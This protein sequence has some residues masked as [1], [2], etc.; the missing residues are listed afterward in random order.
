MQNVAE[1]D[2]QM[3]QLARMEYDEARLAPSSYLPKEKAFLEAELAL[4]RKEM[5]VR[6]LEG[7]IRT[8]VHL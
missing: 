7:E 2:R 1:I 4:L 6:G 5:E 8:F 3:F